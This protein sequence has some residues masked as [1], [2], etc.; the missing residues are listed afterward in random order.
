MKTEHPGKFEFEINNFSRMSWKY[1]A[2]LAPDYI[3][4]H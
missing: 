2:M 1:L 3:V 4:L